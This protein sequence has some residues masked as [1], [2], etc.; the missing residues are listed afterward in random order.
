MNGGSN[1]GK[2]VNADNITDVMEHFHQV[3]GVNILETDQ[4][5]PV[6]SS[7]RAV[8]AVLSVTSTSVTASTA[9]ARIGT[10]VF[11]T[12]S[13]ASRATH[14]AGFVAS[15]VT[16]PIDAYFLVKSVRE[17]KNQSPSEIADKIRTIRSK[18][19]CPQEAE[20]GSLIKSYVG[21]KITEKTQEYTE[22][23]NEHC[24]KFDMIHDLDHIL[25][26]H[27]QLKTDGQLSF[28]AQTQPE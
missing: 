18:M 28:D 20:I 10:A 3:T 2:D 25:L 13:V 8:G 22:T 9:G 23:L 15:V 6:K 19:V 11:D 17:L 7:A 24:E 12:L 26:E 4:L 14:V 5:D 21:A 1:E 16:L 27:D